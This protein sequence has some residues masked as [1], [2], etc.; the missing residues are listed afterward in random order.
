MHGMGMFRAGVFLRPV[1][2]RSHGRKRKI[3]PV[4]TGSRYVNDNSHQ[5]DTLAM[6]YKIVVRSLVLL[7]W[8]VFPL[9]SFAHPSS[10][11]YLVFLMDAERTDDQMELE[12]HLR[13][14]Y[15]F[16]SLDALSVDRDVALSFYHAL[17]DYTVRSF[18]VLHPTLEGAQAYARLQPSSAAAL[19]YEVSPDDRAFHF[20]RTLQQLEEAVPNQDLTRGMVLRFLREAARDIGNDALVAGMPLATDQQP[21]HTVVRGSN[22]RRALIYRNLELV[23]PVPRNAQDGPF[24]EGGARHIADGYPFRASTQ[25]FPVNDFVLSV[26]PRSDN[27]T[28]GFS[29][30]CG[31]SRAASLETAQADRKLSAC[32]SEKISLDKFHR[33]HAHHLGSFIPSVMMLLQ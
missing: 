17:A 30:G 29:D 8:S 5:R 25:A 1:P 28:F 9:T 33:R 23:R 22:I 27:L 14:Q 13:F 3:V 16:P 21:V 12:A 7:A 31:S 32:A 26:I 15:G 10:T 24:H 2:G 4:A 6:S 11:W 20:G 18:I 19:I